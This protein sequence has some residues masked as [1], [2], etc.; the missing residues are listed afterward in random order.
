MQITIILHALSNLDTRTL[1]RLVFTRLGKLHTF[2]DL[3][4]KFAQVV[5]VSLCSFL[6]QRG[7]TFVVGWDQEKFLQ[8]IENRDSEMLSGNP[9]FNPWLLQI[10]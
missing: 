10:N 7:F 9:L 4:K 5:Y 8:V 1:F 3:T 6:V 2:V